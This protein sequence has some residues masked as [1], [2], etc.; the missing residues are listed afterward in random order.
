LAAARR[1]GARG[2]AKPQAPRRAARLAC[3]ALRLQ[4]RAAMRRA[5]LGAAILVPLVALAITALDGQ[6]LDTTNFSSKNGNISYVNAAQC[7]GSDA[8]HLEWK[9]V[10]LQGATFGLNDQIKIYASDTNPANVTGSNGFCNEKPE[11]S[12]V[13]NAGLIDTLQQVTA[14]LADKDVAGAGALIKTATKIDCTVDGSENTNVYICAHWYDQTGN[15]KKG[16]AS[17]TFQ[18]QRLAPNAP[19]G[20]NVGSGDSKLRVSWSASTGTT[21]A[22]HY[23]A[24]AFDPGKSPVVTQTHPAD[25][26]VATSGNVTGT[27]TTI[28]GLTNGTPYDVWVIPF[29]VGGNSGT[30][31]GPEPGTPLPSAS[32]WDVYKDSGGVEQGGCASGPGGAL[33]LLAVASLAALRRRKS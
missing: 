29:S 14:V 16:A 27:S 15:T 28:T 32:F 18:I 30:P 6:V 9:V 10:P 19:S 25:T 11:T 3:V 26:P 17:G 24:A 23:L 20:L 8:L 33:A 1:A 13:I 2:G 4:N 5:L 7:S 12:P 22:D 21:A 31:A